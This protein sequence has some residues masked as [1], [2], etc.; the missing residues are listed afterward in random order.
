MGEGERLRGYKG[1]GTAGVGEGWGGDKSW[2]MWRGYGDVRERGREGCG[3]VYE[4]VRGVFVYTGVCRFFCLFK[5]IFLLLFFFSVIL[6][7]LFKYMFL[8]FLFFLNKYN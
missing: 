7:L 2:G 8:L 5:Y 1:N 6:L 3:R 4:G